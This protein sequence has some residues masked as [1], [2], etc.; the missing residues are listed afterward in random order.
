MTWP[1]D[2]N[3]SLVE[4]VQTLEMMALH[5]FEKQ[6]N[7]N[8]VTQC[9]IPEDLNPHMKCWWFHKHSVIEMKCIHG[10]NIQ[11][12]TWIKICSKNAEASV[13][14]SLWC[15]YRTLYRFVTITDITQISLECK[16]MVM[17]WVSLYLKNPWL[18]LLT[19]W[20]VT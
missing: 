12:K 6:D 20:I 16:E 7:S 9:H 3:L 15:L 13:L 4:V 5:S 2:Q 17:L 8:P 14:S 18:L 10:K 1:L 11:L 19:V